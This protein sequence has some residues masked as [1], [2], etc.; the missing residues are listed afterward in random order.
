MIIKKNNMVLL[1]F[2]FLSVNI[3]SQE[4]YQYEPLLWWKFDSL[5]SG[6]I[7]EEKSITA[8]TVLGYQKLTKGVKGK[9][10]KL[11][12]YTT[13]LVRQSND[14]PEFDK[15]FTVESWIALQALPWNWSAI[16]SLGG[17]YKLKEN[18][19][20]IFV[21]LNN[22]SPGLIGA[23]FGDADLTGPLGKQELLSTDND[24]TGSMN[25]WSNR[26]YSYIEAP[27]TGRVNFRAEADDGLVFTINKKKVID[28]WEPDGERAGSVEMVKG[29]KYHVVLTY[30]ND[31]GE[32][33]LR[34]FWSWD[35]KD[36]SLIPIE[37][38]GY[39]E[40]DDLAATREIIPPDPPEPEYEHKIFFGIDAYGHLGMKL[41]IEGKLYK[42]VSDEKIPLLKWTHVA[43]AYDPDNGMK[44]FINGKQ[45]GQLKIK[46]KITPKESSDLIVGMNIKK[47]GPLGSERQASFDIHSEM[48]IYGLLDET[49]IYNNPLPDNFINETYAISKPEEMQALDWNKM[50]SGPELENKF[51]AFYTRLNYTEE[52]EKPWT[53]TD[54]PDLL[55]HFDKSPVRFIFWRGTSYGGA[56]VTENG[57]WMGDQSLERSNEG[58]SPMGC[59]EHMSDKQ[60]RY[61]SVRIVE[62]NDARIVL[63][64]RYAVS[65]ILYDI[66][67]TDTGSGWGEW[68]DEYYYIYPDGVTTR[69]QTL[70]TNY[71]SHEW[72]ETIVLNQP[73]TYPEDNINL[74]AITLLNMKGDSKTYSWENGPPESF[75]EPAEPNIQMV[76]L[77]SEYKPF[78]IF[79]PGPKLKPF[80]GSPRK[81]FSNFTWWNHWP[82]G[83]LPN[84]GREAFGPDRPSH[85]SLA[86]SVE[87]SDVIHK[88]GD[89]S[90]EVV[91]LI[92]MTNKPAGSLAELARSWNNAPEINIHSS[93]FSFIE[94][95]KKQR[96][97]ILKNKN[98]NNSGK[99]EFSINASNNNPIF[100]PSIVIENWGE[101]EIIFKVN[102]KEIQRGDSL[103]YGFERKMNRTDLIVWYESGYN[104]NVNFEIIPFEK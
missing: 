98:Q 44:I 66:F 13:R 7:V 50:P 72:Q 38:F 82:V 57:I 12:G 95:S 89:G 32:A 73:G 67:G 99:L 45:A 88:N 20:F 69:Y 76:N 60:T 5:K 47:L 46:G 41:N 53:V 35:G 52:W 65:D 61:S 90:Y 100:N 101:I 10:L 48:V 19:D 49:K 87:N 68:A 17:A 63:Q 28:G 56:W 74:D 6:K 23:Q 3:I 21:D 16:I 92:G 26:W 83:Q 85:S 96:A 27:F 97:F 36:E 70:W 75:T 102:G 2:L 78:I 34:L 93:E 15:G 94:Y 64:W 71:L 84:D 33:I 86:Q 9:S 14:L 25:N 8:D 54:Y 22:L 24:W 43:A 81:E 18:S 77:K 11:D 31:G 39:S 80:G 103:R 55:V 79:E 104:T 59:A 62:K 58:K 29:E 91:T 4:V 30:S 42:V 1:L 37:V 40:K 51:D